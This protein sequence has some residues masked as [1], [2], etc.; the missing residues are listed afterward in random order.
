MNPNF[1]NIP[2]HIAVIMDGNG[3]WAKN[4]GKERIYGH[5]NGVNAVREMVKAA[6]DIGVQYL[7]VYAFSTENWGRPSEE[8]DGL[9][10]LISQTILNEITPLS[11]NGVKLM[12]IGDI[13]HLPIEVQ[14]SIAMAGDVVVPQIKLNLVIALN[15]SSRVEIV[16]AVKKIAAQGTPATCITEQMI[17]QN[18]Q[19][20]FMPDPDLLIRTSGEQRLSN[21]M[22]WQL[23][24]SELYFTPVLWPE[25]GKDEFLKAI[26][27]Y[28]ERDRRFGLTK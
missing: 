5:R 4:E 28:N 11:Q 6:T 18:L 2:K 1:Q 21:F 23:S 24:Y 19:T 9:M 17:A 10:Q 26:A 14:K 8:V 27:Q 13:E 20:S 15:Y 3:R 25:F 22:L 7:T 16:N 12:F